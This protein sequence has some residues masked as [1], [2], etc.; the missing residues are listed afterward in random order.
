MGQRIKLEDILLSK[1][2]QLKTVNGEVLHALRNSDLGYNKFG[3]VYFST[4]EPNS[5]NAWKRHSK[6][7]INFIV[8]VGEVRFVFYIDKESGFRTENIGLNRYMR[9]TVP[10]GIWFGFKN[11]S[12]KK[13]YVMNVANIIHDPDEVENCPIDNINYKW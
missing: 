7:L 5:I 11:L 4:I 12:A 13:S 6:M 2:K 10:P 1:L 3:E 9:L 8:P